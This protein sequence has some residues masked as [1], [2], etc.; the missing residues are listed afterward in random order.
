MKALATFGIIS[1]VL[2]TVGCAGNSKYACGVPGGVGCKSVIEVYDQSNS[3][4]LRVTKALPTGEVDDSDYSDSE[5]GAGKPTA[6]LALSSTRKYPMPLK[7]GQ[8]LRTKEVKLRI[9][10]TPWED[11]E[12]DLHDQQFVYTVVKGGQWMLKQN[13]KALEAGSMMPR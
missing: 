11:A 6:S 2:L 12:G 7:P 1:I 5:E 10:V 13:L 3:G 9:W 8:S 4:Q